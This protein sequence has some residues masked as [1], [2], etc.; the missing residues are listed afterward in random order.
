MRW[1]KNKRVLTVLIFI[2]LTLSA[3]IAFTG[4]TSNATTIESKLSNIKEYYAKVPAPPVD[5]I[6]IYQDSIDYL[7]SCLTAEVS[8]Y[9]RKVYPKTKMSP[10]HIVNI[11]TE[12]NFDI[13]LL[14][15]QARQESVFGKHTGGTNSCFGVVKK[16]YRHVDESVTGYVD[17]M[18]RRYVRTRTA[19]Q[20]IRS[21][22]RVEGSRSAKYAE[23][24]RYAQTISSIRTNI[25]RTT[26]IP[27]YQDAI[28]HMQ[29]RL[30]SL[31]KKRETDKANGNYNF[32]RFENSKRQKDSLQREQIPC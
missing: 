26:G 23:D 15:S 18:K 12:R 29:A 28:R 1:L 27:A 22:F 30:D 4:I 24:P 25:I 19:E 21:G 20:C 31:I 32:D 8:A 5:S 6:A 16:R 2:T 17:L 9:M 14:L 13:P 7:K 10:D 3:F 11:C